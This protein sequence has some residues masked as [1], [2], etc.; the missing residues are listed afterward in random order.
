MRGINYMCVCDQMLRADTT[1]LPHD[2]KDFLKVTELWAVCTWER[3][4]TPENLYSLE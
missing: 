4:V 3:E 2:C 1:F